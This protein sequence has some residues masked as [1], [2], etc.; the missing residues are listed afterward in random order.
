MLLF[1][2]AFKYIYIFKVFNRLIV[3]ACTGVMNTTA[4]LVV[5]CSMNLDVRRC[6]DFMLCV[7]IHTPTCTVMYYMYV[8]CVAIWVIRNFE[9]TLMMTHAMTTRFHL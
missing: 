4:K 3:V 2:F 5:S 7:A 1:G 8:V 9:A 6:T